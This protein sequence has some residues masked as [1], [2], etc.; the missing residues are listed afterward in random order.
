MSYE[1][2]RLE[3]L[4]YPSPVAKRRKDEPQSRI[5][6]N[7]LAAMS[8]AGVTPSELARRLGV[9]PQAVNDRLYRYKTMEIATAL[10]CAAA[11]GVSIDHLVRGVD[12]RYDRA[13]VDL[14]R[15]AG[16]E[17]S[18]RHIKAGAHDPATTEIG[19]LKQRLMRLEEENGVLRDTI[20]RIV[21][22][23]NSTH[24]PKVGPPPRRAAGARRRH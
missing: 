1:L 13:G 6:R 12:E 8:A 19:L 7:I 14:S 4:S 15:H 3:A 20:Q 18:A 2:A 5:A 22:S 10:Q 9:P 23:L 16:V 11:L 17:P 21:D 24:S